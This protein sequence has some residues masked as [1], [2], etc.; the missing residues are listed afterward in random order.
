MSEK[1]EFDVSYSTTFEQIEQL[2]AKMLAFVQS[3]RRDY[4]PSFDVVVKDIPDQEKLVLSADIKY[5]SNWQ[6]GSIRGMGAYN[7]NSNCVDLERSLVKRRNKW[8]CALK[9]ALAELEIYGPTGNPDAEPAPKLYTQIP[10]GEV[11]AMKE[12]QRR[13][14][15]A[16]S[17]S[18]P[19]TQK[20]EY[21][22]TD[23]SGVATLSKI[24]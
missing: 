8:V 6:Q 18:R 19:F 3:E 2:R 7:P 15:E 23:K 12:E 21:S 16:E 11:Q 14:K 13:K 24:V 17:H 9:T 10:W 4:Q 20:R 1:F 22:L 5:K